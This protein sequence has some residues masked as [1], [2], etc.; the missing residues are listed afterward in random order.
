MVLS[1]ALNL[2]EYQP[3]IRL[4]VEERPLSELAGKKID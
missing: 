4:E 3:G 1:V 2:P